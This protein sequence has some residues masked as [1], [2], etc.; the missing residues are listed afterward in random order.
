MEKGEREHGVQKI[1]TEKVG[2][3]GGGGGLKKD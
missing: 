3:G 2:G 1:E